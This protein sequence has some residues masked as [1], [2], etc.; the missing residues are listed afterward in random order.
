MI[1]ELKIVI[2]TCFLFCNMS[3]KEEADILDSGSKEKAYIFFEFQGGFEADHVEISVDKIPIYSNTIT[4]D[5]K[6]DLADRCRAITNPGSHGVL[7]NI[8]NSEIIHNYTYQLSDSLILSVINDT[9]NKKL[10]LRQIPK[11]PDYPYVTQND[12]QHLEITYLF[13]QGHSDL[14]PPVIPDPVSILAAFEFR[15]TYDKKIVAGIYPEEAFL[16]LLPGG[17][18]IETM[19]MDLWYEI[20]ISGSN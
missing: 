7:I 16:Y 12:F 18:L 20:Y 17:E 15:N 14:M 2:L 1:K 3:C 6:T 13:G 19:Q 4:T 8:N 11:I 5:I 10:L 9:L